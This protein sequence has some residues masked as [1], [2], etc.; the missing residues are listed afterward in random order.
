MAVAIE[1][2]K[3]NAV[4]RNVPGNVLAPAAPFNVT[5]PA[6]AITPTM[7]RMYRESGRSGRFFPYVSDSRLV[8]RSSARREGVRDSGVWG[9]PTSINKSII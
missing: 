8:L 3:A 1:L 2:R 6:A 7:T 9:L 4:E 5:M